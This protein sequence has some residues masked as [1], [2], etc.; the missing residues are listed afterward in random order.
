MPKKLVVIH[1]QS[2]D[3]LK[4]SEQGQYREPMRRGMRPFD[5]LYFDA[6]TPL[7][8]AQ[9]A[10]LR[11]R[12]RDTY[13]IDAA[14]SPAATSTL[15]RTKQTALIAGFKVDLLK[16]Y[17]VLDGIS[18]E[19]GYDQLIT[20][21]TRGWVPEAALGAAAVILANPPPEPVWFTDVT[22]LAGLC[23]HMNLTIQPDYLWSGRVIELAT[24]FPT[25]S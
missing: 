20:N 15:N 25:V 1:G 14:T 8:E 11:L 21:I 7:G 24:R 23:E 17:S 2:R 9:A 4:T 13:G 6:L 18:Y 19:D 12:L 22:I 10:L 5:S 16:E 3:Q